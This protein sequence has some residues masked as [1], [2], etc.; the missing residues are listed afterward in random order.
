MNITLQNLKVENFKGIKSF[1]LQA[2]GQNTMITAENGVGKTTIYDAFLWLLFNKN[3]E[4]K[5]DFGVHPVDKNN[6]PLK[7]L[8]V[9]VDAVIHCDGKPYNLR[10]E[11]HEKIVKEQLRGYET[12]CWVNEVPKKVSD[13]ADFICELIP[14]ETFKMLTDVDSFNQKLHWEDRRKTLLSLTGEVEKPKGFQELLEKLNG[15]KI[16]EHKNVLSNRKKKYQQEREEINPRI[17]EISRNLVSTDLDETGLQ[18]ERDAKKQSLKEYDEERKKLVA[19]QKERQEKYDLINELE[20]KKTQR[21][22]E[23]KSDTTSVQ[24][25]IDQKNKLMQD[26]SDK[27]EVVT[28]TQSVKNIIQ[29]TYNQIKLKLE[30]AT[31]KLYEI[32]EEWTK[33]SKEKNSEKCYACG[34]TLP[35]EKVKEMNKEREAKLMNIEKEGDKFYKKVKE[36][37]EELTE[38]EQQLQKAQKEIEKQR[39]ELGTLI[40]NNKKRISEL[41]EKIKNNE[42]IPAS[43]DKAWRIFDEQIKRTEKE[44]GEPV[45]VQLQEIEQKRNKIQ[46]EITELNDKLSQFDR[47]KKDKERIAELE[48]KEKELAQ[49]VADIDRELKQIEDYQV[50][51]SKLIEK[52]VN[53]KF[54]YVE[55]KLFEY[56]LN[57][58]VKETCVATLNGVSFEDMSTGQRIL[59]GID[60]INVL[61]IHYD[62]AVPIFIDHAESLTLPIE[63]RSQVIKLF[64]QENVNELKVEREGELANVKK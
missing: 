30:N 45:G 47:M 16:S 28:K 55:F 25:Y 10:K 27:Q 38:A 21:E 13:Y 9:A 19:Q 31:T 4:G 41:D 62:V 12:Q 8:V 61:S 58:S 43:S 20:R 46:N 33:I 52:T 57:G 6:K 29:N 59:V 35:L 42:T 63:A 3:S 44:I 48:T 2:D 11:N 34:Q 40:E 56:Q 54:K 14:E 32:R 1:E 17:D 36:Q 60:I 5:S 51:E 23:L 49:S 24:Q 50:E 18:E 53:D 64:A 15:R 37:K 26:E 22:I 7:G 39:G